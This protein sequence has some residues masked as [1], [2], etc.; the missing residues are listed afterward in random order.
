ML[1]QMVAEVLGI[2]MD[3]VNIKRVDTAMTPCDPGSYGSRV[4][5]LAGAAACNAA[6]DIRSQ[7]SA[8]AAR[9]WKV[10]PEEIAFR[11]RTVFVKSQPSLS[12][13][14]GKLARIACYSGSGAVILGRG[15]SQYGL[16]LYD[17]DKGLGNPGT[18][19][20]FTAQLAQVNVD[21]ETGVARCEETILAHDCGRPLNPLN[22]HSQNQGGAV[23]GIGQALYEGFI[24]DGG[25]TKNATLT[26]YK[27]PL[28]SDV[29]RVEVIDIL[30]DDPDGPFGGEGSERGLHCQHASCRSERAE[31]CHGNLV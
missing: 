1:V 12:M 27:M 19:Y 21:L 28:S 29:P 30:T 5:I 18:S 26:H 9:Q 23:Q 10:T 31:R 2:S 6:R 7:L 4:T 20:S 25:E 14:F 17:W 8:I 13:P 22:V 15:F 11:N 24:M 3:D 16:E